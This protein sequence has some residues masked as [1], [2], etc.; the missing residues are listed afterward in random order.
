VRW[1]LTAAN[2]GRGDATNVRLCDS[3]PRHMG[4]V[5]APRRATLDNG[6]VCWNI[7]RLAA[8]QSTSRTVRTRIDG[9]APTGRLRNR[10]FLRGGGRRADAH[11]AIQV[12]RARAERLPTPVTG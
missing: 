10:A 2:R 3:L 5:R 8:G 9:D 7:R 12:R 6:R 1:T 11:A 4:L